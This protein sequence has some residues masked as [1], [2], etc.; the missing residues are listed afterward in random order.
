[1]KYPLIYEKFVKGN[2]AEYEMIHKPLVG[3]MKTDDK[4]DEGENNS[5]EDIGDPK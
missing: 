3:L 4:E 2:Q 5:E 1:M